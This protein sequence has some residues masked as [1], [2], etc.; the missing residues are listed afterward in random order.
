MTSLRASKDIQPESKATAEKEDAWV[1]LSQ[2]KCLSELQFQTLFN[3]GIRNVLGFLATDDASILAMPGF[4]GADINEFRLEANLSLERE[5]TRGERRKKRARNYARV[6]LAIEN[7]KN[8]YSEE[9]LLKSLSLEKLG[10]ESK[11]KLE[12]SGFEDLVDV[13]L[14]PDEK[15]LISIANLEEESAKSARELALK[16]LN[17]LDENII[18]VEHVE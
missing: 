16:T 15:R 18:N 2:I 6:L 7:L 3:H 11:E 5:K 9:D 8:N 13:F 4:D 1:S 17:S 12:S 14:E 10:I